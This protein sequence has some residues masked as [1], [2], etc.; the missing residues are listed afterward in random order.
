[1]SFPHTIFGKFGDEKETSTAKRRALGTVLELPDGRKF[2]YVKNGSGAI[3]AGKGVASK[4]MVANHDM[5]LVTAA[6]AAGASEVTVTLGGT[7]ATANQYSDGYLYTNDGTGEGQIYRIKSHP[8]ADASA[9]LT[10]T[11]DENDKLVDALDSTTLSGLIENPYNEVVVS[12][13][14]V[15]SRTVGVRTT[16]LAASEYGYV[17]TNGLASILMGGAAVSGEPLRLEG[18]SGQPGAFIKLDRDGTDE[19][20]QEIGVCQ[21]INAVDT[22]YCL[23]F[24]NID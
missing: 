11:L 1:M 5:D 3:T 16:S 21:G 13:T 17:Q 20:E 22:D 18:N 23:A 15:V 14:T 19:N 12:P 8:A 10:L 24:L 7:A 2:K 9:T 4:Q 6:A